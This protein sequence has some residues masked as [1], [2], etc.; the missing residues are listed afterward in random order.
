M[1]NVT[2]VEG[3]LPNT[4]FSLVVSLTKFPI[5]PGLSGLFSMVG[6]I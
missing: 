5:S 6:E 2:D 1:P 4:E 3:V